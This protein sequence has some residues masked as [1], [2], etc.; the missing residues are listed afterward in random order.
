MV[1]HTHEE[2]IQ[3]NL[4]IPRVIERLFYKKYQYKYIHDKELSSIFDTIQKYYKGFSKKEIKDY[5]HKWNGVPKYCCNEDINT[6]GKCRNSL[7]QCREKGIINKTVRVRDLTLFELLSLKKKNGIIPVDATCLKDNDCPYDIPEYKC[8]NYQ[9][10]KLKKNK[11]PR[12]QNK[13]LNLN[14]KSKRS[15][16]LTEYL[17]HS[18]KKGKKKCKSKAK[19][20]GFNRTKSMPGNKI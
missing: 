11:K 7:S 20:G 16:H 10:N 3:H 12:P 17:P 1:C 4:Y 2:C 5:I 9:C 19:K 6:K 14:K 15:L 18:P 8:I 13:I